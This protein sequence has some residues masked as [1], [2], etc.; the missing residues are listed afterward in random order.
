M[1]KALDGAVWRQRRL[2]I[3]KQRSSGLSVAQFCR[4]NGLKT[5]CFHAWKQRLLAQPTCSPQADGTLR[6]KSCRGKGVFV[7]V[8]APVQA[9]LPLTEWI[10]IARADGVTLRVPAS[11]LA[12]LKLVLSILSPNEEQSRA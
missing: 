4:V 1:G 10:E 5:S 6:R 3:E 8:P 11:N 9:V 7:Q 2:W 12:A